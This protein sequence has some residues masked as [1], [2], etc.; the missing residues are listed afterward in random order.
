[1]RKRKSGFTLIEISIALVIIGLLIGGILVA[2]S[3]IENA[4]IQKFGKQISSYD[5]AISNFD[6]KFGGMPGDNPKIRGDICDDPAGC[7][8]TAPLD[9]D[10]YIEGAYQ[11]CDQYA[12]EAAAAW[13]VLSVTESLGKE[14]YSY[15][16]R[17]A[18][19]IAGES[20]PMATMGNKGHILL[21]SGRRNNV[22]APEYYPV[23]DNFYWVGVL[24]NEVFASGPNS[25]ISL[26]DEGTTAN[27][28]A[29]QAMAIDAKYDDSNA[30]TGIVGAM[31]YG[32]RAAYPLNDC[33]SGDPPYAYNPA[34]TV[35]YPCS[36][37]IK[38]F[39]FAGR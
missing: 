5:V 31:G 36:L 34:S 10:G 25:W 28:S 8:S 7:D 21:L 32:P 39:G 22:P 13:N 15:P 14:S 11:Y 16:T 19:V 9:S 24:S 20:V 1:M 37:A 35:A 27:F 3:I 33:A 26:T 17:A 6:T 4:Q 29:K 12:G 23:T 2:Q 30:R 18:P 38:V